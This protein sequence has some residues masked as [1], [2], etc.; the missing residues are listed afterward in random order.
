MDV[1]APGISTPVNP[2]G[3]YPNPTNGAVNFLMPR[4]GSYTIYLQDMSGRVLQ[5]TSIS[6]NQTV[7]YSAHPKGV[8]VLV[9]EGEEFRDFKKLILN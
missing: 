6:E 3:F 8:Y 2:V 7:D 5:T 9:I 1:S 4:G